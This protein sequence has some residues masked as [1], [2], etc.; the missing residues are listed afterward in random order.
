MEKKFIERIDKIIKRYDCRDFDGF[1][2]FRVLK[3]TNK[4]ISTQSKIIAELLNPYSKFHNQSKD[5]FN[6][7]IKFVLNDV[8]NLDDYQVK[9][10]YEIKKLGTYGRIDILIED[11]KNNKA[12]I[13]ENKI[14]AKDQKDQLK[15]YLNFGDEK[16]Q[17]RNN[18]KILYLNPQGS[19]DHIDTDVKNIVITVSYKKELIN[20][21]N[22]CYKIANEDY[23]KINLHQLIGSLK[24]LTNIEERKIRNRL[25]QFEIYKN[26]DEA[27]EHKDYLNTKISKHKKLFDTAI[28]DLKELIQMYNLHNSKKIT[29]ENL[30]RETL[31]EILNIKKKLTFYDI[32]NTESDND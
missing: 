3:L 2:I 26:K 23:L 31:N 5:F 7:F 24:Y 11:L 10:E 22:E 20:W 19:N 17:N 29:L 16:Y 8:I 18:F 4:E 15:R 6:L 21:L 9:L 28:D 32:I 1:N 13:I 14:Y 27:I 30:D 25:I 12:I